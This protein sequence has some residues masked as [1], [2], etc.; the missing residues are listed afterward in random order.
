MSVVCAASLTAALAAARLAT[1][2]DEASVDTWLGLDFCDPGRLSCSVA[3][4]ES[5]QNSGQK[6]PPVSPLITA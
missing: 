2:A 1:G 6:F 4:R 3:T 5:E